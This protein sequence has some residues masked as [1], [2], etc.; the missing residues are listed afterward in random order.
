MVI[1]EA[2]LPESL[3]ALIE[4]GPYDLAEIGRRISLVERYKAFAEGGKFLIAPE[5]SNEDEIWDICDFLILCGISP[6]EISGI[7]PTAY[8][9]FDM[10]G[11]YEGYFSSALKKN[12][13]HGYYYARRGD[14]SLI[15]R[16]PYHTSSVYRDFLGLRDGDTYVDLM[17]GVGD[18]AAGIAQKYPAVQV[19]MVDANARNLRESILKAAERKLTNIK[20]IQADIRDIASKGLIGAGGARAVT[21]TGWALAGYDM[22]QLTDAFGA[23]LR[24]VRPGGVIFFD[25]P[26]RNE[27]FAMYLA[28]QRAGVYLRADPG[29]DSAKEEGVT[30]HRWFGAR[31]VTA[32]MLS[33]HDVRRLLLSTEA[34]LWGYDGVMTAYMSL[35][36]AAMRLKDKSDRKAFEDLTVM[37][38]GRNAQIVQRMRAFTEDFRF[39]PA[40]GGRVF[41]QDGEA[42]APD[43]IGAYRLDAPEG[44]AAVLEMWGDALDLLADLTDDLAAVSSLKFRL[45]KKQVPVA[46]GESPDG[47]M[48]MFND[49]TQL[50][51]RQLEAWTRKTPEEIEAAC[52]ALGVMPVQAEYRPDAAAISPADTRR[53]FLRT[54]CALYISEGFATIF[55]PLLAVRAAF[56][57]A[58]SGEEIDRC[59]SSAAAV[60]RACED[61]MERLSGKGLIAL[62]SGG[63]PMPPTSSFG[64]SDDLIVTLELYREEK[65]RT[66]ADAARRLPAALAALQADLETLR[67]IRKKIADNPSMLKQGKVSAERVLE[68]MDDAIRRCEAV[69]NEWA[70]KSPEEVEEKL[71]SMRV[72]PPQKELDAVPLP[73]PGEFTAGSPVESSS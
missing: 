37:R 28:A 58:D 49:A 34:F 73:A 23:A 18:E 5:N 33:P 44:K 42:H 59:V 64:Y 55:G 45:L 4:Y 62:S 16:Q 35:L 40:S 14:E 32:E 60:L 8:R 68:K 65:A 39:I 26:D 66:V 3:S 69:W 67:G 2:G 6:K 57:D 21:F 25:S 31:V 53:L 61:N 48:K 63:K 52:A 72:L 41:V 54:Q 20:F 24:L 17:G 56:Y 22:R 38:R 15:K 36:R 50:L 46:D 43:M 7:F 11:A 51:T 70:F 27:T 1:G 12:W 10:Q 19:V 30:P 9:A 29:L 13:K 47:V 71:L